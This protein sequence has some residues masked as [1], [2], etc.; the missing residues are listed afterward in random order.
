VQ[1]VNEELRRNILNRRESNEQNAR[2]F[3]LC[4]AYGLR[5]DIDHMFGL[6][7]ESET[8]HVMAAR[9]Y[10]GLRRMNRLKCHNLTCFPRTRIATISQQHGLLS[11]RDAQNM[12]E[13]RTGDFFHVD[14]IR[15]PEQ[16][17]IK[18][19]FVVLFKMLPLLSKQGLDRI[20]TRKSYRW[21]G[22]IPSSLVVLSQIAIAARSGDYRFF[23]YMRYYALRIRRWMASRSKARSVAP[24]T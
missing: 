22:K 12:E 23:L 14:E 3:R 1:S 2:A 5:Y 18:A 11:E 24:K 19:G 6:P 8:D 17:R 10:H 15:N 16:Q 4:D 7:E 21:F 13:G 9:F 20:I